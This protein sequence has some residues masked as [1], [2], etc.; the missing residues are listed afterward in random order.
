M[1]KCSDFPSQ[2]QNLQFTP[3][4]GVWIELLYGTPPP[5]SHVISLYVAQW[6]ILHYLSW[7][8]IWWT[9][10]LVFCNLTSVNLI[11]TSCFAWGPDHVETSLTFCKGQFFF[12]TREELLN[13]LNGFCL[14][15]NQILYLIQL[16]FK[17]RSCHDKKMK[18]SA[19][20]EENGASRR[21][22][23]NSLSCKS[24]LLLSVVCCIA[25][26]HVELRIQEHHRLISS[27]VTYCGQMEKNILQELQQKD[28]Q[29]TKGSHLAG[30]SQQTTG[31]FVKDIKDQVV[32][33]PKGAVIPN[34][35]FEA[36][37]FMCHG[38]RI[39]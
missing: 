5:G 11:L 27:S 20:K 29:I 26:I 9:N 39:I 10:I 19:R 16:M 14:Q 6:P 37:C 22:T 2:T 28:W 21:Q 15:V 36:M 23:V 24:A 32:F 4:S 13:Q 1:G 31:K 12:I 33:E 38:T 30:Q 35:F 34:F 18:Q 8:A 25:L 7:Q 17:V 3:Q